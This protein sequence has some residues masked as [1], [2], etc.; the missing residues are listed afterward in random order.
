[1]CK[2]TR[3]Y[4]A[5]H[6]LKQTLFAPR[7]NRGWTRSWTSHPVGHQNHFV[8]TSKALV[9]RSDALVP[10]SFLLLLVR[11]LLL[12]AWHLLLVVTKKLFRSLLVG[13]FSP[14]PL[15]ARRAVS[16]QRKDPR[17]VRAPKG[18]GVMI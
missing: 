13:A 1:M 4:S 18:G 5:I 3:R 14:F 9:T 10:S 16:S 6:I 12:L 7:R 15:S 17:T 11:H 8:T 2:G